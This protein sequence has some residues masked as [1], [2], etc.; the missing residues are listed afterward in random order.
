MGDVRF[1]GAAKL[2]DPGTAAGGDYDPTA[3]EEAA[4]REEAGRVLGCNGMD[5]AVRDRYD[6]HRLHNPRIIL[7]DYAFGG[8][9]NETRATALSV[10]DGFNFLSW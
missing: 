10:E 7:K 1:V 9:A 5:A 2:E 6:G 8:Y 4:S 3:T